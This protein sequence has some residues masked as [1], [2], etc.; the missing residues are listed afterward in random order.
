MQ[1]NKDA[2][3]IICELILIYF[4]IIKLL[5]QYTIMI[6]GRRVVICFT[7][8]Y[9]K[10]DLYPLGGANIIDLLRYTEH[11]FSCCFFDL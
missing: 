9:I 5:M 11:I 10:F 7:I 8:V 4:I 1:Y 3:T 2:V 6:K